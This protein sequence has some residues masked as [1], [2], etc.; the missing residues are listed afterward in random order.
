MNAIALNSSMFNA[1]RVVGPAVAG[2]LVASIGEGWCFFANAVSYVA[3]IAGTP[4]DAAPR[5]APGGDGGTV[6]APT[7]RGGLPL[8]GAHHAPCGRSSFCSPRSSLAGTPYSS[9]CRSS[10][11]RSSTPGRAGLGILMAASGVGALLGSVALALRRQLRGLGGWVALGGG[12]RRRRARR[13]FSLSRT[14]W[15]SVAPA[16]SRRIR[17]SWSPSVPRTR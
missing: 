1:A 12:R 10:R 11:R 8:L 4:R 2:I 5:R 14:F 6:H 13:S 16:R 3:V 9:S 15:L 7:D 17:A